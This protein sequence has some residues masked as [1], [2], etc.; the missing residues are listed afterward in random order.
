MKD[1]K[2]GTKADKKED[3]G[4][5]KDVEKDPSTEEHKMMMKKMGMK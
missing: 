1:P 2:E 4:K 3:M 5:R